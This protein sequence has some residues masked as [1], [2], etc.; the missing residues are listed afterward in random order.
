MEFHDFTV[1]TPLSLEL[2][3][4]AFRK[5]TGR[6]LSLKRDY[7]FDC[8]ALSAP[9]K[10]WRSVGYPPTSHFIE[11]A[12]QFARIRDAVTPSG[13]TCGWWITTT[14]KAGRSPDFQ[15]MIRRDGSETPFSSCLLDEAY[16]KRFSENV[17]K[18][19]EI[20]HPAFIFTEDDYSIN[21]STFSDG[22]YCPLRLAEFARRTGK[23]YTREE[24]L[25]AFA[26]GS[27]GS[28]K[29]HGEWEK[30]I[31]DTLV[32]LSE[33]I[34]AELDKKTPE[35]PM[36]HMEPG[37]SV[38]EGDSAEAVA[39]ALAGPNHVPFCRIYGTSYCGTDSYAIPQIAFHP[40]WQKQRIPA[41]FRFIHE[42][43]SYPHTRFYTSAAQMR[44]LLGTVYSYGYEGS[45]FQ[46]GSRDD[47][48]ARMYAAER[49]RFE[50]VSRT[51]RLCRV[52]GVGVPKDAVKDGDRIPDWVPVLSRFGIPY[53]TR[54]EPVVLLDAGQA[55]HLSD[56]DLRRIL[57]GGL[58]ADG[59]AAKVLCGRGYASLLGV[60]VGDEVTSPRQK[61]DLAA[62][63]ILIDPDYPALNGLQMPSAHCF[64]SGRGNGKLLSL[65]PTDPACVTVSA[66]FDFSG[67]RTAPTMTRYRN[68]LG[69]RVAVMAMTV[70]GNGSQSLYN[71]ERKQI[72]EEMIR[73]CGGDTVMVEDAP[74][75]FVIQNT[76][77]EPEKEGFFGLITVLN[78]C[79]DAPDELRIRLP[80]AWTDCAGFECPNAAGG[81][82]AVPA[83][84]DG[85]VFVFRRELPFLAP[86]WL[87]VMK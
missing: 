5:T 86:L 24:L 68:S 46:I 27:E 76:C 17:A 7:G 20:A 74:K 69:G 49:K 19:A 50:A 55:A 18:F 40:L 30:L 63:D 26:D 51:A 80:K 25:T 13:V 83:E 4:E 71:Y 84:R 43:D 12:E 42:S 82:D 52:G 72:L 38:A 81:W 62:R 64:A 35:I 10:G 45:V 41:P 31:R 15:P 47:A 87:R 56:S 61:I 65:V 28:A 39:R 36:G 14:V 8:F 58:I 11:L 78:L 1:F 79:E 33:R 3:E 23:A 22:C 57:S 16:Q 6:I 32:S 37:C 48:Y 66:E 34:R 9:S 59:E 73:W 53:S 75:I 60:T 54:M 85:E 44:A 70:K 77:K 67:N 2:G 21:A 29:L